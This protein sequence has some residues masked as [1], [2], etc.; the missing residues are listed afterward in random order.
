[1]DDYSDGVHAEWFAANNGGIG[2]VHRVETGDGTAT[3]FFTTGG[4]VFASPF[5]DSG[6]TRGNNNLYITS[7]DGKVYARK[8][9]NLFDLASG[10][11]VGDVPLGGP[12][13]TSPWLTDYEDIDQ[14]PLT[15]EK[16]LYIGADDGKLYKLNAIDGTIIWQFQAGDKIR[17]NPA[18]MP[19]PAP[20]Q[21]FY[22]GLPE[23]DHYVYFGCDD[24]YIYAVKAS[25]KSIRPGWPVAAGGMVRSIP[26]FNVEE[27]SVTFTCLDGKV[28][29]LNIG[30]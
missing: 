16:Y 4:Q 26:V 19:A 13:Y 28:Y 7:T 6:Y 8:S 17:G 11:P 5:I 27:K 12:I 1:V 30:P 29:V 3:T 25:D 10:W 18:V 21:L 2:T 23:G 14:N 24:G 20:G 22:M 9:A 15:L